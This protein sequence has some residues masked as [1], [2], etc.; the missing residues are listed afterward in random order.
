MSLAVA[1]V[2]L[3]LLCGVA[4]T[5]LPCLAILLNEFNDWAKRT[6]G[7]GAERHSTACAVLIW[8]VV[9]DNSDIRLDSAKGNAINL[10]ADILD[11]VVRRNQYERPIG[12]GQRL[13]PSADIVTD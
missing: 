10:S 9:V 1:T 3:L 8:G 6:H 7:Y 2:R 11:F 13:C 12:R 4:L 5:P